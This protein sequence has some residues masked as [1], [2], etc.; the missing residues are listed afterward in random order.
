[1]NP[2]MVI[3]ESTASDVGWDERRL[4]FLL[5]RGIGWDSAVYH[6]V[7]ESDRGSN[8]WKSR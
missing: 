7:L 3:C 4:R 2:D 6:R 8:G 5:A 1:M